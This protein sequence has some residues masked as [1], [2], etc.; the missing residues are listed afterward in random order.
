MSNIIEVENLVKRYKKAEV[1][2]VDEISFEVGDGEF[3]AFLGPNG[4]GKTT[5]ISILT[6][7]LSKTTGMVRV[8]N[9]D[10]AS[11]PSEVRKRV[12]I[13]FQNPSLDQNLT[14]EENIRFHAVLY[15][16]YSF[17][18][19]FGLMHQDYQK[20]VKE[21]LEIVGLEANIAKPVK[22]FSGGMRRKLEIVRSLMHEPKVLFLDEP[23][24]GLDPVSRSSLWDYLNQVRKR[25]GL[26]IF[27]TT[28][29]LDEVEDVDRVCI[30]NHGKIVYLGEVEKLKHMLGNRQY[31]QVDSENR[32]ALGKELDKMGRRYQMSEDGFEVPFNEY[33]EVQKLMKDIQTPL[34]M[35]GVHAPTLEEAYVEIVGNGKKVF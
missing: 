7:T 9:Y 21:L 31:V 22:T 2:A 4:A 25:N 3:F 18:P 6:T 20:R 1:N 16:V 29:Y 14:A 12:G 33:I 10:V 35:V 28:H 24:V 8:C 19:S 15:G 32:A 23:T 30:V 5:T 34:T 11:Q 27:L 17:A 13:I 26:T